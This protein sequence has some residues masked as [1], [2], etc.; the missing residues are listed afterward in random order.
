MYVCVSFFHG[1][2]GSWVGLA[3]FTEHGEM[4][5]ATPDNYAKIDISR[6]QSKPERSAWSL[7]LMSH[8][9]HRPLLP[10]G[11]RPRHG[12]QWQQGLGQHIR[13]LLCTFKS[14]D[15]PL[16]IM[17]K[18]SASLSPISSAHT[19]TSQGLFCV[20]AMLWMDP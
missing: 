5:Q 10:H 15:L 20:R 13:L 7:V 16:F 17:L 14:P 12:P 6:Q 2:K 8:R 1:F 11:H 4:L 19:C 9:Q 3:L 18:L